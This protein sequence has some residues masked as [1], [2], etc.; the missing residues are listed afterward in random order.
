MRHGYGKAIALGGVM[1]WLAGCASV[2]EVVVLEPVGPSGGVQAAGPGNGSVR[3][4]SAR[5]RAPVDLNAEEFFWNNDFG[6]NEFLYGTT[7]TAYTILDKDGK[8]F[9]HVDNKQVAKD[10]K[11][12]LVTLPAGRYTVD[13]LAEVPG[14]LTE[15]VRV[16]LIVETGLITSVHLEPGWKP[17]QEIFN[18]DTLVRLADGRFIGYRAEDVLNQCLEPATPAER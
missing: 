16:P 17:A 18:P 1:A 7:R 4:Y 9:R 11:P 3:V 14:G 13:T 10:G 5:Q 2:P 8:V 12:P 6:K 15:T